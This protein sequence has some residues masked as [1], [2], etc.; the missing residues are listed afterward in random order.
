MRLNP[1]FKPVDAFTSGIDTLPL[2][3]FFSHF[4]SKVSVYIILYLTNHTTLIIR[5]YQY[6]DNA[7]LP[8]TI[9][10]TSKM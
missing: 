5:Y 4:T 3:N 9:Y 6:V 2:T 10:T 8:Q 7:I 1:V